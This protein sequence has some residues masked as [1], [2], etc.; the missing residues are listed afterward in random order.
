MVLS[1]G[2]SRVQSPV[3]S[4]TQSIKENIKEV[5]GKNSHLINI[6]SGGLKGPGFVMINKRYSFRLYALELFQELGTKT[7]YYKK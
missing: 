4:L 1:V 3:P 6:N 5:S 7:R 2:G